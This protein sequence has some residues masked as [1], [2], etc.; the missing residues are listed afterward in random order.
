MAQRRLRMRNVTLVAAV[1]FLAQCSSGPM[2]PCGP[3][4]CLGCCTTLGGCEGGAAHDACGSSGVFC[5]DCAA[6]G[7]T[8]LVGVCAPAGPNSDGGRSGAAG[9]AGSTAGGGATGGGATGGGATGGGAT[10]GGATGGGATGGGATGGGATGGG[11]TGGGATGG[12]ATGGGSGTAGGAA[13]GGTTCGPATCAGCCSASGTCRSGATNIECGGGGRACQACSGAQTCS[14]GVCRSPQTPDA[15]RLCGPE[16][17]ATGCCDPL[18]GLVCLTGTS[19]EACGA[20]GV[21]CS[22]CL[23]ILQTCQN[24]VCTP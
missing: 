15:G 13:G 8:C 20:G 18:A 17:C 12:G 5:S 3:S 22:V 14:A 6:S 21:V 16:S 9:G 1:L 2:P 24:R 10:G 19:N 11:A 4:N 23:P 7:Q